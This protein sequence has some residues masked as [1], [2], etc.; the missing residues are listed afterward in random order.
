M[1]KVDVLHDDG[2]LLVLKSDYFI[3][4]QFG[5][6][7]IMILILLIPIVMINSIYYLDFSNI[8]I[9]TLEGELG[10]QPWKMRFNFA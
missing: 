3:C 7:I 6:S 8:F 2:D 4:I 9:V 10:F 5:Q 1:A